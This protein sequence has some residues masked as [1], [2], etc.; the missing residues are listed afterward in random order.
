M[1][2][3]P[4]HSNQERN[5]K[6]LF[7]AILIVIC[8]ICIS[9]FLLVIS[10]SF[11]SQQ[12]ITRYG[13]SFF[14][15][16]IS[17]L[18]YIFVFRTKNSLMTS[19]LLTAFISIVGSAIGVTLDSL[20]G[21]VLSRKDY[22]YRRILSFYVFFAI[23]FNGG[24][25]A[26]YILITVWLHLKDTVFALILPSV[27]SGWNI[28]L[29]K[30]FFLSNPYSLVEA[31]KIDGASEFKIFTR[32]VL[33]SSK[34]AIAT[35]TLFY[36]LSL[37]NS[38]FPSMMYC[39]KESLFTLQ[40]LLMK[41]ISNADFMNSADAIQFGLVQATEEIPTTPVKMAMCVLVIVPIACVFPFFQK[42][43]VKGINLGAV[44]E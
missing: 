38:W 42:Y 13:Y 11:Q 36:I 40:Y 30:S 16:K 4:V 32:I 26:N 1:Q 29:M 18:A 2:T 5:L 33:P 14:P 44:K 21:Y 19:Y 25:V 9:A 22:R 8:A 6:I 28:L 12:E 17:L 41:V 35:I 20:C 7:H 24:M 10:I 39:E 37:W 23:L 31:A 43:F 15:R 34:P 27:V 3:K